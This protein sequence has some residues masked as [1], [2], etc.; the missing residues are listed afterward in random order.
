[1]DEYVV[2]NEDYVY[3]RTIPVT[4]PVFVLNRNMINQEARLL[5]NAL[6]ENIKQKL[7]LG[8]EMLQQGHGL[9][10]FSSNGSEAETNLHPTSS[11]VELSKMRQMYKAKK[12]DD[13]KV[14]EVFYPI[15]RSQCLVHQKLL[16]CS[17]FP[18]P[19]KNM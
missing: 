15:K 13:S 1:M 17:H 14:Y 6:I 4:Q 18:L 2:A 3:T 7:A 12:M 10:P 5:Y 8:K 9:V 19:R 16:A 11:S